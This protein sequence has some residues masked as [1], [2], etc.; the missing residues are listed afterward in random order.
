MEIKNVLTDEQLQEKLDILCDKNWKIKRIYEDKM[1]F[2]AKDAIDNWPD[3]SRN[4]LLNM[5]GIKENVDFKKVYH[6]N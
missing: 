5:L 4:Q 1:Y 2:G 3:A 6:K